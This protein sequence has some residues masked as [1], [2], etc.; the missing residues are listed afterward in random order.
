MKGS[1]TPVIPRGEPIR[2]EY[3]PPEIESAKDV[4]WAEIAV[5]GL[6]FPL[7]QFVRGGLRT[8]T[9]E[10][11]FNADRYDETWNVR[12][13]VQAIE[14]LVEKTDETHA[15]P[16]CLF[17]WGGLQAP[18]VI[19]SIS[20]RWTMFDAGG[21]PIEA[22]VTLTLRC[23]QEA[24]VR[25]EPEAAAERPAKRKARRSPVYSGEDGSGSVFAPEEEETVKDAER[26]AS[27]GL[28]KA[29]VMKKGETLRSVSTRH[30]GAPGLWRALAVANKSIDKVR[31][32]KEGIEALVPDP[33]HP[34]AIIERVTNMPPEA[35][36]ALRKAQKVGMEGLERS[37]KPSLG[38]AAS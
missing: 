18:V 15:P 19:G 38:M 24:D 14:T 7:Q 29:Q 32:V 37:F 6:D 2:F 11:Y 21:V 34:L 35:I 10:V 23:Y 9:V 33:R 20:T 30:Y 12:E 5:P 31:D 22:T 25:I 17:E 16:V 1:I 8:I 13:S 28:P 3:N 36:E 4:N 27:E 26:L